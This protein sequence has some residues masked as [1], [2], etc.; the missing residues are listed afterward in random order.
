M[1]IVQ[2]SNMR[3]LWTDE[4]AVAISIVKRDYLG[5]MKPLDHLQVA[6]VLYLWVVKFMSQIFTEQEWG[7]RL[8]SLLS[9]F[10]AI[11]LYWR[12]LRRFV[13]DEAAFLIG[14]VL[15]VFN[16]KLFYYA[17]EV[18]QYMNDVMVTLALVT[19]A[20]DWKHNDRRS[21]ITLSFAGLIGVFLS[22]ITVMVLPAVF[23]ICF[24]SV[25]GSGLWD[26][27]RITALIVMSIPWLIGFVINYM[28][29]I[30]GHPSRDQQVALWK[31]F[32]PPVEV[33][34]KQMILFIYN[35]FELVCRDF[36]FGVNNITSAFEFLQPLHLVIMAILTFV[37][38]YRSV[39]K[40]DRAWILLI[41][42]ILHF[43]LAYLRLYP[44][45]SRTM[46][47]TYPPIAIMLAS[48]AGFLISSLK[49]S[50]IIFQ[51]LVVTYGLLL[52]VIFITRYIPR[53][54]EESRPVL[55]YMEAHSKPRLATYSFAAG[56]SMLEYYIKVGV[57]KPEGPVYYAVERS[58]EG[59][60]YASEII[61]IK[62]DTWV[63]MAHYK[64]DQLLA[65]QQALKNHGCLITDSVKAKGVEAFYVTQSSR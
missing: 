62:Q 24:L 43:I 51:A 20:L 11:F 2:F 60:D 37:F 7:L 15:F 26:K 40:I 65:I 50:K 41:P 21:V 59:R 5:L 53:T 22:N 36:G 58:N 6:P 30:H 27:R 17:D 12:L 46:L 55:T 34:S 56:N 38:I 3:G 10:T 47:Y 16:N 42:L 19:L 8:Y 61:N 54:V 18:K 31:N 49:K 32:F 25:S 48:G 39:R 57:F 35:T 4:S 64:P 9:Y 28:L 45:A 52:S 1:A 33:F 13:K 63:Y 14:I 23:L 29:F 44:I